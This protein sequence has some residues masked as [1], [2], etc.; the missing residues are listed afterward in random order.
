MK[1][2]IKLLSIFAS[3]IIVFAMADTANAQCNPDEYA[4]K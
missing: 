2:Q 1:F 4:D 3:I